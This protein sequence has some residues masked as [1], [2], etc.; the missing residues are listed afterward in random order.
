MLTD[1]ALALVVVS[2]FE[3]VGSLLVVARVV[4]PAATAHLCTTSIRRALA[5]S[6]AIAVAGSW[7]GLAAS[8]T[9]ADLGRGLPPG[10]G[11][12][13]VVSLVFGS[14][15]VATPAGRSPGT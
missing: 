7:A 9:F 1:L 15:L 13:V 10:P 2:A 11:I 6:I 3:A 14:V 5:V 12:V 4:T 8:L